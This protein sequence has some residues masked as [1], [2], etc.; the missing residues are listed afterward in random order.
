MKHIG[1]KQILNN[2]LTAFLCSDKYSSK[3]VL[4]SYDWAVKMKNE[5]KC[6][7]SGFH[8]KLERDVLD[9]LLKGNSPIIIALGRC[10]YKNV[11]KKLVEHIRANRLLIISEFDDSIIFPN[12]VTDEARN[13]KIIEMSDEV[14]IGHVN[15]GGMLD[16]IL[17]DIKKPLTILDQE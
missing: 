15:K 12:K 9:I 14:V 16:N 3:S 10:I 13:R 4:L 17:K 6:V 11:P 5:K 1:N 2:S 8:S 7:I